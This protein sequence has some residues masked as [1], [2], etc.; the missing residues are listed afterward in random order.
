[1]PRKPIAVVQLLPSHVV[2]V[3]GD[4]LPFTLTTHASDKAAQRYITRT[5]T[6]LTEQDFKV[7]VERMVV[8]Q[9]EPTVRDLIALALDAE[10]VSS[11]RAY[12][13][14]AA[15]EALTDVALGDS[16][17]LIRDLAL[18]ATL[19]NAEPGILRRFIH[20]EIDAEVLDRI[21]ELPTEVTA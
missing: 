21:V 11:V 17:D 4:Q 20:D 14:R 15:Q 1:M 13:A 16:S 3:T 12:C 18:A 9:R 7:T 5:E 10:V 8:E 6:A 2:E 19:T